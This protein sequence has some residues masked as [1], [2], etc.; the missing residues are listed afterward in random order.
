[1]CVYTSRY[2]Q[3]GRSRPRRPRPAPRHQSLCPGGGGRHA[4]R[5]A[6]C[7]ASR[8]ADRSTVGYGRAV[9]DT[10]RWLP[11]GALCRWHA[12][13]AALLRAASVVVAYAPR[14]C[15]CPCVSMCVS[16]SICMYS[17]CAPARATRFRPKERPLARPLSLSLYTQC[18]SPLQGRP[19]GKER[20]PVSRACDDLRHGHGA[21][22]R[23]AVHACMV[24][25]RIGRP[26]DGH[27]S[28]CLVFLLRLARLDALHLPLR[29]RF[30]LRL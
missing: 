8:A 19:A 2:R 6:T 21:C 24:R 11:V 29:L 10:Q 4:R 5:C 13:A 18:L 16:L 7:I 15:V 9:V 3:G 30:R 28:M 12:P 17:A 20:V 27:R 22:R 26:R 1:M 25:R 14:A 23:H